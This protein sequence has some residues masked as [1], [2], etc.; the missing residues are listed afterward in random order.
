MTGV[1][2][3]GRED[4]LVRKWKCTQCGYIHTGDAPPEICPVCGASKDKFVE[5]VPQK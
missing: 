4:R 5:Y 3:S 2:R 1:N